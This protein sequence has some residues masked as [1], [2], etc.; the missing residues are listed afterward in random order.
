MLTPESFSNYEVISRDRA[1]DQFKHADLII[2]DQYNEL[3]SVEPSEMFDGQSVLIVYSYMGS[4]QYAEQ[5]QPQV[6]AVRAPVGPFKLARC[7]LAVLDQDPSST[8]LMR[9]NKSISGKRTPLHSPIGL[10]THG[11]PFTDLGLTQPPKTSL[12]P[13]ESSIVR[14]T[15]PQAPFQV[16]SQTPTEVPP[17]SSLE[18]NSSPIPSGST[19]GLRILAVDD[20]MLN[21]RLI[22]RYLLK[23]KSHFVS[24]A[25]NGIE[26]VA[27][28]RE[29]AYKD[30]YFDII[31]MDI[32]MPEMDGFEATRLIRSFERS[33]AHRSVAED[34]EISDT[35]REEDN[36]TED[37]IGK[38]EEGGFVKHGVH[39]AYIVALTGLASRRDRDTADASGFD[40][41]LTKP[42]SFEKIEGLLV[43]L[44]AEKLGGSARL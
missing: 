40:D 10:S 11:N 38:K 35:P 29:A 32:S 6:G 23:R 17:S 1:A 41:F 7:I 34:V 37:R 19:C 2:T 12:N 4:R 3:A 14:N 44:S 36:L 30:T 25:R 5:Y 13:N 33:F 39:R 9:N 42:V 31:F 20:N 8:A 28:V 43:Q 22:Y 16:T 27:S 15:S 24:T 18:Q 26:A 21:L